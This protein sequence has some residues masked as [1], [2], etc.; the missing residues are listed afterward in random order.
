MSSNISCNPANYTQQ[1]IF[2]I[3]VHI[4]ILFIILS[5]FFIIIVNKIMHR[6]INKKFTELIDDN[7]TPKMNDIYN[8]YPELSLLTSNIS[9]N[10][11]FTNEDITVTYNNKWQ[12][13]TTYMTI[14]FLIVL[15]VLYPLILKYT[16]NNCIPV[17]HIIILN[18]VIFSFIGMAE[19]AFFHFIAM[20]YIPIK[21][22]TITTS[23]LDKIKHLLQN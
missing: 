6:A 10:K 14:A 12:Y 13:I 7:M 21:P 18:I 23:I 16:C 15:T 17:K 1:M 11:I 5:V 8:K 4:T 2:N 20:N 22:S 19:Y 3:N 9:S